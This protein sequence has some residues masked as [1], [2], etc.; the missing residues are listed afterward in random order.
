[1]NVEYERGY[2]KAK[3]EF[4]RKISNKIKELEKEYEEYKNGQEWEI[5]DDIQ[6]QITILQELKEK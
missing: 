3:K 1:M 2:N 5:Q 6:A 4:E